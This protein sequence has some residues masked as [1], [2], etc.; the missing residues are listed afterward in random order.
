ML[1]NCVSTNRYEKGKM[2][3]E[4]VSCIIMD[5]SDSYDKQS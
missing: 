4:T 5:D 1:N 2:N 3:L